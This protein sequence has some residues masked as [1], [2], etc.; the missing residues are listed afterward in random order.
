MNHCPTEAMRIGLTDT[1]GWVSL[2]VVP[3]DDGPDPCDGT[4][5][6]LILRIHYRVSRIAAWNSR[7]HV[8][9]TGDGT[10]YR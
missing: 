5:R 6:V 8:F 10:G 3:S 1:E 7:V 9:V 4:T 2:G